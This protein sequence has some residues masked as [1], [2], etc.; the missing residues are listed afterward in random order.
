MIE[1]EYDKAVEL[2]EEIV[3]EKG[4][5]CYTEDPKT[6]ERR[7]AQNS[8]MCFYANEDGTPGCIIGHLVHKLNPEF[9]LNLIERKGAARALQAAGF[10][11]RAD[12]A[13][14]VRKTQMSQDLGY[15]WRQAV[16]AGKWN[17]HIR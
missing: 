1:L 3:A 11:V 8:N 5:Y 2:L 4:D 7:K 12:A 16:D 10:D 9:D 17:T 14:L 15:T 13:T 6:D